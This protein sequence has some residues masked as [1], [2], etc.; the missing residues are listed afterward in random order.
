M[1]LSRRAASHP[2]DGRAA[3][4]GRVRGRLGCARAEGRA[5]AAVIAGLLDDMR[6]AFSDPSAEAN[7]RDA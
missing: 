6:H 1:G 3:H 5:V 7:L 4:L 2:D